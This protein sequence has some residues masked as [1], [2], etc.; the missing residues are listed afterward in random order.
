MKY[1]MVPHIWVYD[2]E[3]ALIL[4]YGQEFMD[5]IEDLRSFL[6]YEGFIKDISIS[7]YIDDNDYDCEK[8]K[9]IK[10]FLRDIF[11]KNKKILINI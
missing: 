3:D 2:L 9:C 7:F 11:P 10:A 1:E 8:I 6:F 4:Q 5:G